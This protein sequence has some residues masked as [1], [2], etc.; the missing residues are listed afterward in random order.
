MQVG[1]LVLYFFL[2][3]LRILLDFSSNADYKQ[4]RLSEILLEKNFKLAPN[5]KSST[6]AFNLSLVLLSIEINL[7]AKKQSRKRNTFRACGTDYVKIIFT[8]LTKVKTF[9]M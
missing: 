1:S 8:L 6:I 5:K 7:I 4:C 2:L 9:H 3:V